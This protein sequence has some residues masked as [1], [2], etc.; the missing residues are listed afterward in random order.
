MLQIEVLVPLNSLERQLFT[1]L[2]PL[3]HFLRQLERIVD[4][5]RFRATLAQY[6]CPGEGRPTGMAGTMAKPRTSRSGGNYSA[7]INSAGMLSRWRFRTSW[8]PGHRPKSSSR[9]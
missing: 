8:P 5:E 4:F 2:V 7:S 1:R 6:Y 9:G 3:D